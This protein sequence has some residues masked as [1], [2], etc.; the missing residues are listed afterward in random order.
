MMISICERKISNTVYLNWQSIQS[1]RLFTRK[2]S[3]IN[4]KHFLKK[5]ACWKPIK[6][7]FIYHV[8]FVSHRLGMH[9]WVAHVR[10]GLLNNNDGFTSCVFISVPTQDPHLV[11][12]FYVIQLGRKQVRPHKLIK[13]HPKQGWIQVH[14][15]LNTVFLIYNVINIK[16][17]LVWNVDFYM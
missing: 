17:T 12:M 14:S 1:W 15:C 11:K 2:Y 7:C 16:R 10:A 5:I 9:H 4:L 8:K 6:E 13:E 3:M